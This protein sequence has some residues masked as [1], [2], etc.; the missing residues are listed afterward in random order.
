MV[1]L[2]RHGQIS[3]YQNGRYFMYVT[4]WNATEEGIGRKHREI[5]VYHNASRVVWNSTD[6]N[7]FNDA[8]EQFQRDP[9]SFEKTSQAGELPEKK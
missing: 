8:L 6:P 4:E 2:R 9:E 3:E 7:Q 5:E 1:S